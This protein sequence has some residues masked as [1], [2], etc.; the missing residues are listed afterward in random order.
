MLNK[1]YPSVSIVELDHVVKKIRTIVNQVSSM[2]ELILAFVLIASLLVISALVNSSMSE[3]VESRLL[4]TLV[5]P[6]QG[7]RECR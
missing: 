6:Q 4:R 1:E 7:S 5:L 3:R 2:I